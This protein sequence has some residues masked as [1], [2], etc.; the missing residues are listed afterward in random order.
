M[1]AIGLS[2]IDGRL[3]VAKR[4]DSI[5]IIE[6]GKKKILRN[7]FTGRI[8]EVNTTL[9]NSLVE[10]GYTPVIAPIAISEEGYG[11]NCD[12]DRASA[13]IAGALSVNDLI[14]FTNVPGLLE[15]IEDES[16]L[17]KQIPKGQIEK[18]SEFAQGRMK[19]KIM[20]ASEAIDGGVENI[21]F[22]H[23]GIE[24]PLSNALA[25]ECTTIS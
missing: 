22:A 25:G 11:V 2:G 3:L 24:N 12:G 9:L 20:G 5:K 15:N 6:N 10:S 14:I 4:K 18:F 23:G 7:D 13:M 16:S 1:N 19:K 21:R 17:I 8:T